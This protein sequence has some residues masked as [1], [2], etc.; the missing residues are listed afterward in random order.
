MSLNGIEISDLNEPAQILVRNAQS[1]DASGEVAPIIPNAGQST[2]LIGDAI[3]ALAQ[4]MSDLVVSS[5]RAA[6]AVQAS[7][8]GYATTEDVNTA[9]ISEG[10]R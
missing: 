7:D 3:T 1:L 2:P 10:P 5:A 6:D 4:A 8:E 9:D